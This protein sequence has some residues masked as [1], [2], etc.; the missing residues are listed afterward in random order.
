MPSVRE[1]FLSAIIAGDFSCALEAAKEAYEQGL[2]Y[3]YE[4]LVADALR[5]V[6]RLWQAGQLSV[7]DEH[8]ATAVA[9][10]V[11]ANFYPR[12]PWA[13]AGPKGVVACIAGEQHALGARMAADLLAWDGWD[14]A[15]VGADVPFA[16]LAELVARQAPVFVGLSAALPERVPA[17]RE[18]IAA[19]RRRA[20]ALKVLVGGRAVLSTTAAQLGADAIAKTAG[21]AVEVARSWKP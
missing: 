20:P 18:E 11:L 1:R 13:P 12:F 9:Q 15:F 17:L 6:G 14:V 3:L 5:E 19:L 21:E 8:V 7:A 4:E 10:S 2:N 16:A